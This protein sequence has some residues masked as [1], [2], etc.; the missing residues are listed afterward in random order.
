MRPEEQSAAAAK[1]CEAAPVVPV[2]VIDDAT[3]AAP[4]ATALV[5]GGL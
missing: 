5:A 1:I 2:L 4:L 3:T